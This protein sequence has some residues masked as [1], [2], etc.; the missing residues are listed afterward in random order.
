MA[1]LAGEIVAG[2]AHGG[3]D[4]ILAEMLGRVD[5][6]VPAIS[7][8]IV[9]RAWP[10]L[11]DVDGVPIL[12]DAPEI[13]AGCNAA[14]GG[15]GEQDN[16]QKPLQHVVTSYGGGGMQNPYSR[17]VTE[18]LVAIDWLRPRDSRPAQIFTPYR[19]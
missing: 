7:D 14:G 2:I 13:I 10:E 4:G 11:G 12:V 9:L 15:N 8:K 17:V 19:E 1:V 5:D 18:G 6:Q 16:D 3:I